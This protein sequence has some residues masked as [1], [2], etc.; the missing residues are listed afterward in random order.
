M[1]TTTLVMYFLDRISKKIS[2]SINDP[3][4]DLTPHDVQTAMNGIIA[5]AVLTGTEGVE[6][7]EAHSAQI[8]TRT[9]NPLM[10]D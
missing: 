3:K 8:V 9:V 10:M 1:E 7:V 4:V 2:V 6:L 5:D